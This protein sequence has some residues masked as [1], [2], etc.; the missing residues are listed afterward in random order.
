M[1]N[2][3]FK[4]KLILVSI[5]LLSCLKNESSAQNKIHLDAVALKSAQVIEQKFK[6]AD[7]NRKH[8]RDYDSYQLGKLQ[9]ELSLLVTYKG[10]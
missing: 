4:M 10:K 5:L 7:V 2:K 9:D 3:G 6:L 8:L 1:L